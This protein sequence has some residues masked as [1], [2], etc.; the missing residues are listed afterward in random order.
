MTKAIA[1]TIAFVHCSGPSLLADDIEPKIVEVED[2]VVRFAEELDVPARAAGAI[3]DV[4][5]AINQSVRTGMLLAKLDDENLL[6][7]LEQM[8]FRIAGATRKANDEIES[9]YAAAVLEEATANLESS[10]R[11]QRSRSGAVS[12]NALRQ[13]EL[14]VKRAKLG[15]ARSIRERDDAMTELKLLRSELRSIESQLEALKTTSPISGVVLRMYKKPGEWVEAG[16]PVANVASI[17][18]LHVH[19]LLSLS[20]LSTQACRRG[21]VEVIWKD[22]TTGEAKR[23]SGFVHSVDPEVLRGG[24]VRVHAEIKNYLETGKDG[25]GGDWMLKPGMPVEMKIRVARSGDPL[26]AASSDRPDQRATQ[27]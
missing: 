3:A 1:L 18:R 5:V 14:A 13:M 22:A 8:E 27:R 24:R 23:L 2:C 16:Q 19:A 21:I 7:Q 11:L 20:D 9:D 26:R 6:I 25:R 15:V 17:D 4:Q 12:E 10:R